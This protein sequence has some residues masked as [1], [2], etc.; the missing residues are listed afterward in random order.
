MRRQ[1][2]DLK[3]TKAELVAAFS[4]PHWSGQF[5]PVL[6]VD[7]AAQLLQVPRA[8]IYEWSSRGLLKGC[9]RRVGKY[10]RLFRD[11]LLI[12]IFNE[13]LNPDAE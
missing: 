6:S 5:P 13:G 2:G 12:R 10:L 7:Q 1:D 8:T 3:L 11:R 9:G 4:D